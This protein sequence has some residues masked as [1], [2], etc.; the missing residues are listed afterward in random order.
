MTPKQKLVLE[1]YKFFAPNNSDLSDKA[2]KDAMRWETFGGGPKGDGVFTQTNNGF[3]QGKR[4]S[5]RQ[6]E[7]W[8]EAIAAGDL[9]TIELYAAYD[10][11]FHG[12]LHSLLNSIPKDSPHQF[13]LRRPSQL[14]IDDWR[15]SHA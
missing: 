9:S 2:A 1:F 8:R 6:S 4:W 7:I 11:K 14:E 13:L 10:S 5:H 12:L 15:T 3:L